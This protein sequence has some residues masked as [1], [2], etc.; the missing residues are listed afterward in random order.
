MSRPESPKSGAD[1]T[2]PAP[3]PPS[4]PDPRPALTDL[5][6]DDF[7]VLAELPGA[8]KFTP[9]QIRAWVWQRGARNVDAMTDLSKPL[10][11]ALNE[12]Y[13]VRRSALSSTHPS[14]DGTLGVLS[15]LDDGEVIESVSIPEERRH[16]LCL[17]SQV[18]CAVR[19]S[20]CASG[21]Q[22]VTRNLS[23]GEILEQILLVREL[24]PELPLSN[25]V[26][27]GSGEPTHNLANVL[28][29]I[30][31]MNADEGLGIGARR[32]TVSTVGNPAALTKLAEE[33]IPF[34]VALSLHSPEDAQR[35][36]L[37]PG[38][39][40]SDL[41]ASLAAARERFERNHRRLTIEVAVMAGVNDDTRTGHALIE[42]LR[43]YPAIVN[44]IPWNP[45]DGLPHRAPEAAKVDA[46]ADQLGAAGLTT[47]VR[48][49]RGQ[50][51]G[52]ACGQLRR[53]A[54]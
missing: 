53:H 22:G 16:T 10:R 49:P 38:L 4:A 6:L 19:C 29:A 2:R 26:F 35:E 21:Q 24:R 33:P 43:G 18:G 11:A 45:V 17:S 44:L 1:A 50:D 46:L 30:R 20:F 12:R 7:D 52:V 15:R 8:R 36:Q 48:R 47:T 23:A 25:Y 34:H 39:G 31:V 32:I 3:S 28:A 14:N 13:R 51:V 5:P 27:M 54:H 9:K 37:M 41:R 40:R 42:L